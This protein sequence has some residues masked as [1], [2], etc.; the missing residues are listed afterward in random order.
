MQVLEKQGTYIELS[1]SNG[2]EIVSGGPVVL[3]AGGALRISSASSGIEL[4]APN[5]VKLKQG[6]TEMSLGG[7]L[8]MSGAQIKL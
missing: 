8:N 6:D 1:D 4:S 2:V 3:S 5:K 7:D